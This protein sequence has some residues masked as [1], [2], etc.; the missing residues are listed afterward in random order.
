MLSLARTLSRAVPLALALLAAVPAAAQTYQIRFQ[1]NSPWTVYSIQTSPAYDNNWGEDFLYSNVMAPGRY[2][3]ITIG[4][5]QTCLYDV[6]IVFTDGGEQ[7]D[8]FDICAY[9][10]YIIN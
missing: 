5:V 4:N 8:Q 10:Q 6:R 3:D 9:S 1:N 2:L 7:V